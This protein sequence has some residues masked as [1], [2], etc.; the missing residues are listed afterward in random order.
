MASATLAQALNKLV[1]LLA[2]GRLGCFSQAA[3]TQHRDVP[4]VLVNDRSH[5]RLNVRRCGMGF[6]VSPAQ[7]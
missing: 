3:Q 6:K 4:G 5:S 7:S 1:L 2:K